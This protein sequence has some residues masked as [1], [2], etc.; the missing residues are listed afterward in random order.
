MLILPHQ[1][2][3]YS[4][5]KKSVTENHFFYKKGALKIFG[6]KSESVQKWDDGGYLLVYALYEDH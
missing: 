3:D 4:L 1:G 2:A 6:Q 5:M